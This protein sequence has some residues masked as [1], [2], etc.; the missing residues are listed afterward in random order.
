MDSH[1]GGQDAPI[2]TGKCK[3]SQGSE[4]AVSFKSRVAGEARTPA[5]SLIACVPTGWRYTTSQ[6]ALTISSRP[7]GKRTPSPSLPPDLP[8]NSLTDSEFRGLARQ[9]NGFA[10]GAMCV[11]PVPAAQSPSIEAGCES[12]KTTSD[13]AGKSPFTLSFRGWHTL[14]RAPAAR[15]PKLQVEWIN[16]LLDTWQRLLQF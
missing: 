3:T 13:N 9:G 14:P 10:S 4:A 2:R 6:L 5:R 7:P 12:A 8:G 1:G 15:L 16:L 11:L